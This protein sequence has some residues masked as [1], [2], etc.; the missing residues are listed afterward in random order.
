MI[1]VSI[2]GGLGNQMYGYALYRTLKEQG[3]SVKA[4]MSYFRVPRRGKADNSIVTW[5]NFE[6]QNVF[7]IEVDSLNAAEQF[8]LKLGRKAKLIQCYYDKELFFQPEVLNITDGLLSG[9]WQSFKY[10]R[11]IES[12]LR[13]EFRFRKPLTGRS[14]EAIQKIRNCNSVS[15]SVRR[16]DYVRLGWELPLSYYENAIRLIREKV[17]DAKFFCTSDDIDWCKEAWGDQMEYIDWSSGADQYFDM[18]VISECK[19]NILANSTF[20]SW[21]AWMNQNENKLVIYPEKFNEQLKDRKD[22]WPDEWI[23]LPS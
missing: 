12:I 10:S 11:E 5:R 19:H 9:Y 23:G 8:L 1:V 7:G 15:I 6:L 13:K 22:F 18:Q 17:P 20:C 4:D 21:G 3:K 2:V 16:G 14:A